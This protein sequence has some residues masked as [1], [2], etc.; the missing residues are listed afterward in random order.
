MPTT[1]PRR[2]QGKRRMWRGHTLGVFAC[3]RKATAVMETRVGLSRT[4]YVCDDA[5]CFDFIRGGYPASSR[6]L[7]S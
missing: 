6:A 3:G 7:R 2:C 1:R 5:E 4:H